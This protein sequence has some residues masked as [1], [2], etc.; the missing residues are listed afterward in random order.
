MNQQRKH[1]AV[2]T[3]A[4]RGVGQGIAL[5]L[6]AA[7]MTVFVT[8][9]APEHGGSNVYGHALRGSLEDTLPRLLRQVGGVSRWSAIM[10]MM[11]RSR[12]CSPG[13]KRNA[14]N[15]ICW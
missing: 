11:R 1:V 12:H 9:R 2:V 8:G 14:G 10:P 15:W 3:G 5:A 6:G 13:L 7:G 4:S